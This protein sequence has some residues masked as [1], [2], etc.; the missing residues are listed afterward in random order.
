LITDPLVVPNTDLGG[1]CSMVMVCDGAVALCVVYTALNVACWP[2]CTDEDSDWI[3]DASEEPPPDDDPDGDAVV[4]DPP[5][6]VVAAVLDEL[7][8]AART[9]PAVRTPRR[10]ATARVPGRAREAEEGVAS[11]TVGLLAL[12]RRGCSDGQGPVPG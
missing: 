9:A 4:A 10:Q 2:A 6:V 3:F 8:H 11:S 5:D 1:I 12:R 7:L